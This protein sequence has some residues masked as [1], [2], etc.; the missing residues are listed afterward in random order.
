MKFY[1]LQDRVALGQLLVYWQPGKDNLVDYPTKYQSHSHHKIMR[2]YFVYVN[3]EQLPNLVETRLIRGCHNST[4]NPGSSI[5]IHEPSTTC[6]QPSIN[7]MVLNPRTPKIN[8]VVRNPNTPKIN[9]VVCNPCTSKT[10]ISGTQD[11]LACAPSYMRTRICPLV[12]ILRPVCQQ[13]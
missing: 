9:Y 2:H 12:P 4:P 8:S 13:F 1:W 7:Y 10:I 11:R 5:Y 3:R 6:V